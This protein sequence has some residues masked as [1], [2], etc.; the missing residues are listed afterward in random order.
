MTT[1]GA[2]IVYGVISA[3]VLQ[4]GRMEKNRGETLCGGAG[5]VIMLVFGFFLL[6]P[7]L[8][9]GVS[10]EQESYFIFILWSILGLFFFRNLLA[11]DLNRR[12]ENSI[13]V[14]VALLVMIVFMGVVWMGKVFENNILTTI[15]SSRG[16]YT[17]IEE[18]GITAYNADPFIRQETTRLHGIVLNVEFVVLGLFAVSLAALLWNYLH[19]RRTTLETRRE[20]GTARSLAYTDPLTGVKSKHAFVE[21]EMHMDQRIDLNAV[22]QFGIVIGDINGT[23][24]VNDTRGHR[25]GDEYIHAGCELICSCFKFSPVY[26][27]GGDEFAVLLEGPDY[28]R[29]EELMQSLNRQ[30]EQNI[31]K[32]GPVAALG[33]AVYR[34]GQDNTFRSVFERADSEMYS[35]KKELKAMGADVRE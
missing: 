31:Q 9:L 20:L 26:R 4:T 7:N 32:G 18:Q 17:G 3:A 35:R 11:H 15:V 2:T 22:R 25:A 21:A 24:T 10:M 13:H 14:W 12:F 19:L 5:I 1:V 30:M 27:I 16:H 23:K 28:E 8:L 33:L 6:L 29:R 34:P